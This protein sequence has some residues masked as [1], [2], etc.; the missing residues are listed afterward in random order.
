MRIGILG[1]GQLGRMTAMAAHCLG[2]ETLI[3]DE[4][5]AGKSAGQISPFME[6]GWRDE[7]ALRQF[8]EQVDAITYEFENIPLESVKFLEQHRPVYPDS[9]ALSIASDRIHEKQFM[10]GLSLP[11]ASYAIVSDLNAL[12]DA[13][14]KIGGFPAILKTARFGY[15]GYGQMRLENEAVL[16]N[17]KETL[18][19]MFE[20]AHRQGTRLVVERYLDLKFEASILIARFKN[21]KM[22]SYEPSRNDHQNQILHRSI[23]PAPDL[24]PQDHALMK[25]YAIKIAEGC[26]YIGLL[27]V[28]CFITSNH[29]ILI[30]EI[31][32]R[33]HNSGHWTMDGTG[34][35]QFEQLVRILCNLP[36]G[37]PDRLFTKVE[38]LN[39]LGDAVTNL[40]PY[41]ENPHARLHLYGKGA[42]KAGRKMGHVNL[43]NNP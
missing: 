2:I 10:D 43:I 17:E 31:A 26:N 3:Y 5:V 14:A 41:L 11:V 13:C 32:P 42:I 35:S 16:E 34:C 18:V 40:T 22:V 19:A 23:V 4:A 30:N 37:S 15:D 6:G 27:A 20:Q 12:A 38:M 33:P 24:T 36:S 9:T 25:E 39:L 29:K 21:G 7:T 1:S 28:E 8:A